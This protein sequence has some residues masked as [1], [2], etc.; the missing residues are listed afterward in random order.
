[1]LNFFHVQLHFV[2]ILSLD[3]FQAES[4]L[5]LLNMKAQR[6]ADASEH[7]RDAERD[8]AAAM[9]AADEEGSLELFVRN[10]LLPRHLK[11]MAD[12][13]ERLQRAKEAAKQEA[14]AKVKFKLLKTWIEDKLNK[15]YLFDF[16]Y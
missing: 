15:R 6:D 14:K 13:T 10:I 5:E 16:F 9:A 1:M 4:E 3:Y 7:R 8:A 2:I 12:L 11:E